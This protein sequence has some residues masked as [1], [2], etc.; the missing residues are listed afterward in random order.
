MFIRKSFVAIILMLV[1]SSC[2]EN[3][4]DGVE[5]DNDVL[6]DPVVEFE[7][8]IPEAV[9]YSVILNCYRDFI[10][11]GDQSEEDYDFDEAKSLMNKVADEVK[12][13]D[14]YS[15]DQKSWEL[16]CSFTPHATNLGYALH[17]INDD[18]IP[19]LII[20]SDNY[21]GFIHAIYTLHNDVPVFIGGFWERHS[22]TF[23]ENGTL[24]IHGSSGALDS[25]SGSYFLPE[26][27]TELQLIEMYVTNGYD[28][29]NSNPRCYMIKDGEK[30]MVDYKEAMASM[31][32]FPHTFRDGATINVELV[33]IPFN[34]TFAE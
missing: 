29:N 25:S 19:E 5:S 17:D 15:N 22:C 8:I 12:I 11:L 27:G 20:F 2:T 18:G 21:N 34:S 4:L 13:N 14:V 10:F 16:L 30:T 1:F 7:W 33:H 9:K 31:D 28:E 32:Q 23:D 24:Y 6:P 26:V 3:L